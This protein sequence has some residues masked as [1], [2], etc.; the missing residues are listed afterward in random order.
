MVPVSHFEW[1]WCCQCSILPI[2]AL[3]TCGAHDQRA[4]WAWYLFESRACP[5]S[6][7]IWLYGTA[8][9]ADASTA[10]TTTE[11]AHIG[12]R[13]L[14][15]SPSDRPDDAGRVAYAAHLLLVVG[16]GKVR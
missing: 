8:A 1:H 14:I 12:M 6:A 13:A 16:K 10:A 4:T 2:R 7:T 3:L 5:G 11:T 9:D 15:E